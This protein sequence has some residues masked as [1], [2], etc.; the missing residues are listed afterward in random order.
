MPPSRTF[1]RSKR[2][3]KLVYANRFRKWLTTSPIVLKGSSV[4]Y[5][6]MT[7]P[8]DANLA[9]PLRLE[10][11]ENMSSVLVENFVVLKYEKMGYQREHCEVAVFNNRGKFVAYYE[12]NSNQFYESFVDKWTPEGGY[13]HSSADIQICNADPDHWTLIDQDL[14]WNESFI[15][16]IT[17]CNFELFDSFLGRLSPT[18]VSFILMHALSE[19]T[20]VIYQYVLELDSVKDSNLLKATLV[21]WSGRSVL[22]RCL[23][24][25]VDRNYVSKSARKYCVRGRMS[26]FLGILSSSGTGSWMG[27]SF[28]TEL[29]S[30]ACMETMNASAHWPIRTL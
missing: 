18:E 16:D 17:E 28:H 7:E 29:R 2:I 3:L 11:I 9:G 6:Q 23:T 13:N 27:P 25:K 14:N 19:D 30:I 24:K 12:L 26:G 1:K 8:D 20:R 15:G 5:E 4:L 21:L 22:P 10:T